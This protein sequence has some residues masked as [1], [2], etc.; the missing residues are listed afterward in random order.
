MGSFDPQK[1]GFETGFKIFSAIV[2]AMVV[3]CVV[4]ELLRRNNLI[5]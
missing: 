5:E 2:A 3:T 4:F 1:D